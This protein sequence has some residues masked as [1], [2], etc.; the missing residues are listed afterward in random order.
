MKVYLTKFNTRTVVMHLTHYY[1][2]IA[3]IV[4]HDQ[5]A[6][7]FRDNPHRIMCS[8]VSVV[9]Y[10]S[11]SAITDI[12]SLPISLE[13]MLSICKVSFPTS[14]LLTAMAPTVI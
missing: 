12:P 14:S 5:L 13:L 10:C 4:S 8:V 3:I 6:I 1:V 9:L 2:C 7:P 11:C